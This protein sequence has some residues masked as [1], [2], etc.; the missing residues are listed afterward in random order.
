MQLKKKKGGRR[1][2]AYRASVDRDRRRKLG[3]EGELFEKVVKL[4]RFFA[5]LL[6]F[7][8]SLLRH[9]FLEVGAVLH[10]GGDVAVQ[11]E[12]GGMRRKRER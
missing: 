5:S 7:F 1:G 6:R 11:T 10:V 12:G 9:R 4:L 8:A 3:K 2:R